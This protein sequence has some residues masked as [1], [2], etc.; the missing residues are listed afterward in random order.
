MS[1]QLFV[2]F[3]HVCYFLSTVFMWR[4]SKQNNDKGLNFFIEST[5]SFQYLFSIFNITT[6]R[7]ATSFHRYF[8]PNDTCCLLLHSLQ[9]YINLK[10]FCSKSVPLGFSENLRVKYKDIWW[11]TQ[12]HG[13]EKHLKQPNQPLTLLCL[14]RSIN[15]FYLPFALRDLKYF[16][17]LKQILLLFFSFVFFPWIF[18]KRIRFIHS[19]RVFW[20]D[21]IKAGKEK[22]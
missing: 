7:P 11:R 10:L 1:T 19:T 15:F 14:N 18:L 22:K 16:T 2:A 5:N 8:V 4:S 9:D 21:W 17:A 13:K 6:Q 3:V 20:G 12:R